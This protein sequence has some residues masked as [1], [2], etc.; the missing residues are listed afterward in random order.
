[1]AIITPKLHK[2]TPFVVSE[3]FMQ[4]RLAHINW[5]FVQCI[6]AN[7]FPKQITLSPTY[8]AAMPPCQMPAEFKNI[9]EY[10]D[11][12]LKGVFE[13][14]ATSVNIK[15]CNYEERSRDPGFKRQENPDLILDCTNSNLTF[16]PESSLVLSL[17]AK[18][19][20]RVGAGINHMLCCNERKY[21]AA[22]KAHEQEFMHRYGTSFSPAQELAKT[23]CYH[24]LKNLYDRPNSAQLYMN[25][26]Y[27]FPD[28]FLPPYPLASMIDL[29]FLSE[30]SLDKFM[31]AENPLQELSSILY[32]MKIS[33]NLSLTE[34]QQLLHIENLANKWKSKILLINDIFNKNS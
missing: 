13:P 10:A 25:Q 21:I 9:V 16:H 8:Y 22:L 29:R 12:N 3:P 11:R 17:D 24:I 30:K 4:F 6:L 5:G 27:I 15:V 23:E 2:F 34:A 28:N 1:V 19:L 7:S 31:R 14:Y 26:L 18:K 20:K 33:E 32:E